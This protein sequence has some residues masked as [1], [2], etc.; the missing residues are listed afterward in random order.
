MPPNQMYPNSKSSRA[1]KYAL[2]L[3]YWVAVPC[4]VLVSSEHLLRSLEFGHSTEPFLRKEVEGT[5]VYVRNRDFFQ[6]FLSYAIATE[7]WEFS[8]LDVIPAKPPGVYRIFVFG[9]SAPEGWPEPAFSF[10]RFL[11]AMLSVQY[12]GV[13]FEVYNTAFRAVNSHAMR[14]EAIAC[15][16]FEPD[17]FVVYLG[18]NEVHGPFGL[19]DSGASRLYPLP[20]WLIRSIIWS[21]NLRLAQLPTLF[22]REARTVFG[23]RTRGAPP[24]PVR[25]DD[26]RLGRV[27]EHFRR[28][29]GDI[30]DAAGDAGIPA[31]LCTV[32]VNLRH[33]RPSDS[34]HLR[35]LNGE[36]LAAWGAHLQ[37]GRN[38][39]EAGA[40]KEALHAYEQAFKIDDTHAELAF[41]M[42]ECCWRLEDY[43]RASDLF[44]LAHELDGFTWVRAKPAINGVVRSVTGGRS[45]RGVTLVDFEKSVSEHAHH[46]CPGFD[47]FLDYCHF[48][49]EGSYLLAK[50]V[51][52]AL[53]PQLPGWVKQER[54][55]TRGP[56]EFEECIQR[57]GLSQTMLLPFFRNTLINDNFYDGDALEEFQRQM[58][59]LE[60]L[61][62]ADRDNPVM[63]RLEAA[64]KAMEFPDPDSVVRLNYYLDLLYRGRSDRYL[65]E[66]QKLALDFPYHRGVLRLLGKYFALLQRDT[67]ALKTFQRLLALYP[68]DTAS[69]DHCVEILQRQGDAHGALAMLRAA[70]KND[71]IEESRLTRQAE[72]LR[73]EG[74]PRE[75]MERLK[76]AILLN[77]HYPKAYAELDEIG[78]SELSPEERVS[79]WRELVERLDRYTGPFVHLGDALEAAG[80][81]NGARDAFLTV[82]RKD[83]Q[84]MGTRQKLERI[85]SKIRAAE[86]R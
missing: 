28:N 55:G 19:I 79:M 61:A 37:E 85:E 68:D 77:P 49:F 36:D 20:L 39:H 11:R 32:A 41:R 2:Y 69:Y 86:S 22:W 47:L 75:A 15:A 58:A 78:M 31:L 17:A 48:N 54:A 60:S 84:D 56:L 5:S 42:A 57:L 26:P 67:E 64:Q 44:R 24:A 43:G 65:G 30:C 23:Q 50:E 71:P 29:L 70:L 10:T 8:E 13:K 7:S 12:P 45:A 27:Y 66:V 3:F 82:L 6:Q 1:W 40:W 46:G 34:F 63:L 81:F 21:N 4:V 38:K 74:K 72:I 83:A 73:F 9:E 80:D 52:L 62:G 35:D 76:K 25:P 59:E 33:W 53:E 16:R 51:F 18:N 14:L